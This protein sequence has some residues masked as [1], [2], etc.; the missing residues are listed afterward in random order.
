[1]MKTEKNSSTIAKILKFLIK[2]ALAAGIVAYLVCQ[3]TTEIE[4]GLETFNYYWLIP[5]AAIY[6]AHMAVSALR[7][8]RLA[9]VLN[10]GLTRMEAVS[11]S[12][13]AYFF[14]L[15]VPG[16]AIGGDLVKI[17]VLS[18][19]SRSGT[20]VE[21]AFTILMDR[22]SGMIALFA[23]TV[24]VTIPAIPVLMNVSLPETMEF[25][26]TPAVKEA[27]IAGLFILCLA[28]LAASMAVFFH[29]TMEKIP[30]VGYLMRKAD[31]LTHGMIS[32]M[33]AATDAYR[34]NWP[35]TL[36]AVLVSIP[37]VHLMTAAAFL[38]LLA[39]SGAALPSLLTVTAAVTIGNIAGLLPIFPSGIGGRDVTVIMILA[40]GGMASG[41]AK[42][43][44]LI[45]TALMIVCQ[46]LA[47]IFFIIDPGPGQ[48]KEAQS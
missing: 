5:A 30:P 34:T 46:L 48:R 3:D 12:M 39:G 4:K 41:E 32:R 13:Q 10:V 38:C 24:A 25:Q 8:H 19:R 28:G 23:L 33:T 2:F 35:V 36:K 9:G 6:I 21:G 37:F 22:I 18:S 31:A 44:Q 16:G 14:S 26:L 20:K 27:G 40:A 43:V 29:R 42:T 7:W 15:V 47:G 45:Y 1:M 17:G 11:L